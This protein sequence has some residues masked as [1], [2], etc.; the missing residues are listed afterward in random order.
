[1]SKT[2]KALASG[3]VGVGDSPN[4]YHET[5]K[6]RTRQKTA[7]HDHQANARRKL[8]GVIKVTKPRVIKIHFRDTTQK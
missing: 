6:P 1:M 8:P 5:D 2:I 7:V 4:L 3:G